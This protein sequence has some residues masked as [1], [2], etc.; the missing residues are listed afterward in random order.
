MKKLMLNKETI[1]SLN[2][3]AMDG[4]KGGDTKAPTYR[5]QCPE[6]PSGC[7][8]ICYYTCGDTCTCTNLTLCC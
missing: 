2:S 6:P 7:F 3:I 8:T 4:I 1:A 5:T